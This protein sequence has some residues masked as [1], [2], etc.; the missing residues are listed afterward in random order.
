MF[1]KPRPKK[2]LLPPPNKKRKTTSAVEEVNFDFD[3]RHEYLTGFHKRKQQRIKNAQEEAAKREKQEKLETRRQAREDRKRE[4]EEHVQTVNR[5][6]RE[7]GAIPDEPEGSDEE[8]EGEEWEGLPDPP[9]VDIVDQEE[10]YIDE[11]RYTTVTVESVAVS[12]DGF[13]KPPQAGDEE[14][15][16]EKGADQKEADEN[17]SKPKQPKKKKKKFRYE[18]KIERQLT[19]K[20]RKIKSRGGRS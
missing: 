10:E 14:D 13:E 11:D 3:A 18:T 16:A 7:S 19:E 4:V 9:S 17:E 1:A 20:K 2:S 15:E 5:M 8:D 6:L 12:R